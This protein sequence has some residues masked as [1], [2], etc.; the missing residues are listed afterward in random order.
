MVKMVESVDKGYARALLE[1]AEQS[2]ELAGIASEVADIRSMLEHQA[3]LRRLLG[4]R[5]LAASERAQVIRNVFDGR[6]TPVLHAF[7]QVIN[8]KS[9]LDR[10]SLILEAFELLLAEKQGR[11][12]VDAWVAGE[13][14]TALVRE[15]ADRIGAAFGKQ[16]TLKQHVDPSLVGGM[17]I[18]VGDQM[19]DGTVTT[20]LKL[21]R[22][23]M[24]AAGR[25]GARQGNLIQN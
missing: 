2:G 14:D 23:G 19:I 24:I 7:L 4:S 8:E 15:V 11:M 21:I 25:E 5:V 13:L 9:R 6:V 12:D 1:L 3:D 10:L 22:E 20:Q 18:R 17:K 16:V